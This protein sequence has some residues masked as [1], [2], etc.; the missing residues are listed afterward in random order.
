MLPNPQNPEWRRWEP[1]YKGVSYLAESGRLR[2]VGI[3][4]WV[5]LKH[6]EVNISK[7]EVH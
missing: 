5:Y 6:G 1:C 7:S 3:V 2:I 4:C